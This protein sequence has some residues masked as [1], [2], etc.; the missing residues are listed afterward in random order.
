MIDPA[1][2][3]QRGAEQSAPRSRSGLSTLESD[4]VARPGPHLVAL[5]ACEQSLV[6]F[7]RQPPGARWK[8]ERRVGLAELGAHDGFAAGA[9][10]AVEGGAKARSGVGVPLCGVGGVGAQLRAERGGAAARPVPRL[11][12]APRDSHPRHVGIVSA[13]VFHRATISAS[14]NTRLAVERIAHALKCGVQ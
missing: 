10:G 7:E 5:H 8:V 12:S 3:T 13:G 1:G 11:T 4:G 14:E 2:I 9:C 6:A